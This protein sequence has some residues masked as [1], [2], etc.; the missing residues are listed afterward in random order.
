MGGSG[1]SDMRKK[2]GE[3]GGREFKVDRGHSLDEIFKDLQ[4]EMRSQYAIGYPSP[5]SSKDGAY[6]KIEIKVDNKDYKV[7]ARKGYYA[8]PGEN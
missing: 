1:N 2:S 4:E 8:I 7:Q 5:N 6:H 3:T